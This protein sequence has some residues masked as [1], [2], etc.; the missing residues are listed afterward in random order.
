MTIKCNT[1]FYIKEINGLI[2]KIWILSVGWIIVLYQLHCINLMSSGYIKECI[3]QLK[4]V[5]RKGMMS[6]AW[7]QGFLLWVSLYFSYFLSW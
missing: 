1:I 7:T 3:L 4:Y 6:A 5:G 2:V